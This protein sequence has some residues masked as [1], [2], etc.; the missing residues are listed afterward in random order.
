MR[1]WVGGGDLVVDVVIVGAGFSG[2]FMLHRVRQLGLTARVFEAGDDVGGTWYW[3]RYPGARCDIE[4][5]EYSYS[6]DDDLQQEW[7]WSERFASQPE[8]L[9]YLQHVAE[10]FNL[11]RDIQFSTRVTGARFDDASSRWTVSTN[12]GNE[13]TCRFLIT[14][15]GCLSSA[16]MPNLPGRDSFMGAT[17]HTGQ[18]PHEGVDFTGL[19]VGVIGTGSS[20]VQ[21][22]P[23]I[24]EQA[25]QLTVFQRTPT[26][27]A[28]A[29]NE[30]LPLDELNKVKAHYAE[31]RE[32]N[33][34]MSGAYGSRT[35]RG[36][37][38]AF[39]VS[40]A[41]R[42][43]E[44]QDRW[45]KGGLILLHGFN[46]LLLNKEA[47]ETAA[48]FVRGKI[49]EIVADA[50]VATKL[51]P[52]HVIGCKRLCLGTG[53]YETYNRENVTLVDLRSDPLEA[54]TPTGIRAGGIEYRL[55]C[56]VYAT[57]FDAM[58]GSLLKM[59]IQGPTTSLAEAWEAGPRTFL[60]LGVHGLP[61]LFIITGPGSPSVL[62]N[63]VASI[64][65]HVE[66][67]TGCLR[68]MLAKGQ[69]RIEA[70][71]DAQE[72]WVAHVNAVADMTL[73]PSC[74]SWYLGANV[75]G[76]PRVFM[77]LPGHPGYVQRCQAIAAAGYEGFEIL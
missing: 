42:Q 68:S 32:G 59:N 52:T 40:D 63:M 3:N 12:D 13:S 31:L 69:T 34:Q 39:A 61:N 24:A 33:Q 15:V 9:S 4:S 20:A 57:G 44:Y 77:P 67:I 43:Q 23:L 73:F 75:P 1:H 10:R 5:V 70:S 11:R 55:D 53:Y 72:R 37:R 19:R 48:E 8:I 76:K 49:S 22:I 38:S 21:S 65:F 54:V 18:W 50:D 41:E 6:F 28:P 60:G 35:T 47:N 27:A 26:Y 30:Q 7:V 14:A 2:L 66:W 58:T 56:I 64:E 51:I 16:N 71:E 74:N 46:D 36:D 29:R 45:D 62:S 25:S 17:Y